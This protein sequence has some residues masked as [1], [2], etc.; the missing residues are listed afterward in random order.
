MK[1]FCEGSKN[2]VFNEIYGQKFYKYEENFV[3]IYIYAV[4]GRRFS[5]SDCAAALALAAL[6]PA[7]P[8]CV[9][10]AGG[11]PQVT[12]LRGNTPHC[13]LTARQDRHNRRSQTCGAT[14]PHCALPERQDRHNRRSQPCGATRRIAPCLQGR[15]AV[16]FF[17]KPL[18]ALNSALRSL[19]KML[20]YFK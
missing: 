6:P 3:Y 17:R 16:I 20:I 19:G 1:F 7:S 12:A 5:F 15:T 14:P 11:R 8:D 18:K 13:A 4:G 9:A 2:A 10:G